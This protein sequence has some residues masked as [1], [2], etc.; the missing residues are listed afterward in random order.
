MHDYEMANKPK[1]IKEFTLTLRVCEKLQFKL[2]RRAF[3]RT[4]ASISFIQKLFSTEVEFLQIYRNNTKL[5]EELL[6]LKALRSHNFIQTNSSSLLAEL[7]GKVCLV[8]F[9]VFCFNRKQII[10]FHNIMYICFLNM[11]YIFFLNSS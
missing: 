1:I 9:S 5:L 10:V 11:I 4:L 6:G 7:N 2:L 8:E 3:G